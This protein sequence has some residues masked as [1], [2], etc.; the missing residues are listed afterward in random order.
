LVGAKMV[1]GPSPETVS[2]R[3]TSDKSFSK[4]EAPSSS[5]MP[6]DEIC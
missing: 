2:F 3:S 5:S 6:E 4:V 1:K